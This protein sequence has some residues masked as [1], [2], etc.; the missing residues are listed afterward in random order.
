MTSYAPTIL[1]YNIVPN[2]PYLYIPL[3]SNLSI[4]LGDLQKKWNYNIR[5][6]DFH[7]YIIQSLDRRLCYCMIHNGISM[8]FF[9][10]FLHF[11]FQWI[12]FF[13][14]STGWEILNWHCRINWAHLTCV[15]Q[16]FIF[17]VRCRD[18]IFWE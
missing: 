6:K 11:S 9:F 4:P 8:N 3:T 16:F 7:L 10:Y 5:K 2:H 14:F 15:G 1:H 12:S 18:G 13:P 17:Y